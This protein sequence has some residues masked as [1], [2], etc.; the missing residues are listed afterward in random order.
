VSV[1]AFP[2]GVDAD[3][4]AQ[5]ATSVGEQRQHELARRYGIPT[6][7]RVALGVDR[8]DYTKGIPERIEAL[9]HLWE[10]RPAWRGELT[11]VQKADES[12][13]VI[14]NYRDLQERVDAAITRVN[15]RFGTP[16]WDPVVRIDDYLDEATLVGLYRLADVMLVSALRDGMNLVA[17]EYVAAQVDDDGVLVLSD[18]AGAHDQLGGDAVSI[19]PHNDVGFS[20]AIEAALSMPAGER[21]E[22]MTRLRD[23]V[24]A[25]DVEAWMSDVLGTVARL[26]AGADVVV[27]G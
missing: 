3:A 9:E 19:N 7:G 27:D 25:E 4:I 5:T 16:E 1:R 6:E 2:L 23:A 22:R 21:R 17:K 13:S 24:S 11:Y 10:T 15:E 8:L 26:R 12:R 20:N 14:P 18:Q